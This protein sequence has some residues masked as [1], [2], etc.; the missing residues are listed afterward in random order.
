MSATM[1]ENIME[2][3]ALGERVKGSYGIE[4]QRR[5]S[6]TSPPRTIVSIDIPLAIA[7]LKTLCQ[8]CQDAFAVLSSTFPA[9][10]QVSQIMVPRLALMKELHMGLS[11]ETAAAP[12]IHSSSSTILDT[13]RADCFTREHNGKSRTCSRS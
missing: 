11:Y 2:S 6:S 13:S 3:H 1:C 5:L 10:I 7:G 4:V 12:R 9:E 8:N